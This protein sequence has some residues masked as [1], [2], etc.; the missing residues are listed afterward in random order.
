MHNHKQWLAQTLG[1]GYHYG[2]WAGPGIQK[3][4]HGL[5]QKTFFLFN[6]SRWSNLPS[7]DYGLS[8]VP[9]LFDG[10]FYDGIVADMMLWLL[11]YRKY[12]PEGL[13]IYWKDMDTYL[14]HTLENPEG[15]WKENKEN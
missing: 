1:D 11:D 9:L 2:E 12:K 10:A 5:E 3:N 4:R 14:K 7:N 8:C 15:K 6:S 13:M